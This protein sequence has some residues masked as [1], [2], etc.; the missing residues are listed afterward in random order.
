MREIIPITVHVGDPSYVTN[1]GGRVVIKKHQHDFLSSCE[2]V[3]GSKARIS[4]TRLRA[5]LRSVQPFWRALKSHLTQHTHAMANNATA[6]ALEDH[7]EVSKPL[8]YTLNT[9]GE[10][11]C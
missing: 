3:P 8:Y 11:I 4:I 2:N 1:N 6:A 7:W 9:E 5:L 10:F